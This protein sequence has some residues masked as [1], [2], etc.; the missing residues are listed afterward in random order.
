MSL[1]FL[2]GRSGS[3]KTHTIYQMLIEES[4]KEEDQNYFLIVPEQ[5]TLQTQKDI[6]DIHPNHGT[7]NID[8]VSFP[9]LAYRVFEELSYYPDAVLEDMGKRMVL[10][11]ILEEEKNQLKIFGSSIQKPGF[12]ENMKSMISELYQYQVKPDALDALQSGEDGNLNYKLHDLALIERKFQEY[13]EGHFIVAEQILEELSAKVGNSKKIRDSVIYLDGFTGFTPVQNQLIGTLLQ[14]AKKIVISVTADSWIEKRQFVREYEL[15]SMSSKM[16]WQLKEI[17]KEQG[18][19]VLPS[20][21]LED[22]V[23]Y[24]LKEAADLAALEA[25]IFRYPVKVYEKDIEHI[26]LFTQKDAL[27]E[28][29]RICEKIEYYVREK[30][31][32]YRDLA[33]IAGDMDHYR[34]H[35]EHCFAEF[36]IP[37]FIDHKK[38]MLNNPCVETV[39][40][41]YQ[42]VQEN[43]S[44]P[45]VFRYL[46]AGM[47]HL[48]LEQIDKLENYV[49]AH[50]IR[51]KKRWTTEFVVPGP[52]LTEED[53]KEVN[54]SREQFLDEVFEFY[55]KCQEKDNTVRDHMEILYSFLRNQ[56]MEE[57]ME[58]L[59]RNFEDKKDYVM[60]KTYAQIYPY[61]IGLMDKMV[62]ILGAEKMSASQVLQILDS[63]LEE[64]SIG[65]IPPGIDQVVVGDLT[66]TRLNRIKVLFFAGM[67]ETFIPNVPDGSGVLN[68]HERE[69]L[70]EKG[71]SLAET[72][73]Q[74]AYAEQFYL[75]LAI[76]KPT[77]HLYLSYATVGNDGSSMRPSYF[78]QRIQKVLP[79]LKLTSFEMSGI[80]TKEYG[81]HRFVEGLRKEMEDGGQQEWKGIGKTLLEEEQIRSFLKAACYENHENYLTSEAAKEVYGEILQNSIS[82]LE[83]FEA[84]AYAHFLRYGLKLYPRREFKIG[85]VDLGN[86]FHRALELISKKI[87]VTYDDWKGIDDR[88]Q[89]ILTEE[90]V[91]RALSEWNENLLNS[92]RR[93]Q[94]V[95]KIIKRLTRR[96]L[97]ALIRHLENSD[98]KPYAFEISFSSYSD[99]KSANLELDHGIKMKLN[100]KIDRV[101]R[102]E[103]EDGI[104]LK[105]IDYKSG[106]AKFDL[107][108]LYY[109]LQLQLVLYMNAVLEIE[110][111]KSVGK[112]VI[113]AGIFYY[114][115]KD[116]LVDQDPETD[117]EERILKK[118]QMDGYVNSDY[119]IID[120]MERD[121]PAKCRSI[122]VS[123][124]KKGYSAY[125]KIMDTQ[126]FEHIREF[127]VKKML[128]AGNEMVGGKI[129][130]H[131]YRR[132]KETACDYCEY[133][134]ICHFDSRLD[135]YRD[136]AEKKEKELLEMWKGDGDDG[137]DEGTTEC[138]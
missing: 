10:R 107:M 85:S 74:S 88:E 51:G 128:E 102:Y 105:V 137:M 39:R 57:Q 122:P 108:N 64:M 42:I 111:K 138:D 104:Y 49:I 82:R 86:V 45:S 65:V 75:Y 114:S 36:H 110:E 62:N 95:A 48:S 30:G 78:I 99:L 21:L 119:H 71:L 50:G 5:Y 44:Y 91:N 16:I 131:P 46:K 47:S 120:H 15:F 70:E 112:P 113:P 76:S 127:A 34:M 97:W 13:L 103:D 69:L 32:R 11:K 109:G 53:L 129:S 4:I 40:G 25:G 27:E 60:E 116:P 72:V 20:I 87:Q 84:C 94:Y 26:T 58:T 61:M 37:Y 80:Y 133:R 3:G 73:I 117:V 100:G 90:A 29:Y 124:T 19:Q 135:V 31:Y 63:G 123:R 59:R 115:L 55:S 79:Q 52:D 101:D 8:V 7:M 2:I 134:E 93:N 81:T 106:Y 118:L 136:L 83:Q 23:P 67:N 1:Q 89:E 54:E 130:I 98:F 68:D 96:T 24:R 41:I 126:T 35:F 33:V 12:V 6:V 17:A 18:I 43:F 28:V 77:D 9:R 22:T 125:S 92:S 38:S 66:R 56:R 132:K 121:L 14:Y